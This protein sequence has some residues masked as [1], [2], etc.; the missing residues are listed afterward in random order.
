MDMI[1]AVRTRLP[2][3]NVS[4][5]LA[6]ALVDDAQALVL[7]YLGRDELPTPCE[8]AVVRMAV[9]L[10]NRMGM[11]GEQSRS[12]GGVSTSVDLIP[13]DIAAQLRPW[14]LAV[15]RGR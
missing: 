11:E 4:L 8:N 14:R 9:V 12:E 5:I 10:F 15:T 1:E 7:G 3:E 6:Q 2:D 13:A